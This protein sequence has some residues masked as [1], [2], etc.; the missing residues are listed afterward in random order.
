M[1]RY[2]GPGRDS[3]TRSSRM[4]PGPEIAG[5]GIGASPGPAVGSPSD[6]SVLGAAPRQ[7]SMWTSGTI[8]SGR[9]SSREVSSVPELDHDPPE[10]EQGETQRRA[11]GVEHGRVHLRSG[12]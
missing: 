11:R 3:T 5:L 9:R 12:I 6:G 1:T 10:A 7:G 2:S 8:D 4:F